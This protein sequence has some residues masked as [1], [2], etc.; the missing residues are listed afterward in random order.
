MAS[1]PLKSDEL[2]EKK[3][4]LSESSRKK[5]LF[6]KNRLSNSISQHTCYLNPK[7]LIQYLV[8]FNTNYFLILIRKAQSNLFNP[9]SF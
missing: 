8:F 4:S 1:I 6:F 3:T 2:F 9:E 5:M 7:I